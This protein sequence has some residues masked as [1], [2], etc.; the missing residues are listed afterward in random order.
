MM[1]FVKKQMTKAADMVTDT[2]N[3]IKEV[4]ANLLAKTSSNME[5]FRDTVDDKPLYLGLVGFAVFVLY[6]DIY[7]VD[8]RTRGVIR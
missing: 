6:L 2:T 8:T 7:C 1:Q 3:L 4:T 5:E